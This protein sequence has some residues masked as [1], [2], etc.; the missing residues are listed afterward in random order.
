MT[1]AKKICFGKKADSL[2]ACKHSINMI[3]DKISITWYKASRARLRDLGRFLF[4]LVSVR[5]EE[6]QS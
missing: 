3:K 5:A 2:D 4:T 1:A 6:S